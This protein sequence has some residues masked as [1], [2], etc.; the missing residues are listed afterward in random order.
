MRN[1]ETNTELLKL[2][3]EQVEGHLEAKKV[4]LTLVNR[5]KHRFHQQFIRGVNT[6]FLVDPLKVL[7][8]GPSGTGKTHLVDVLQ[9]L[10]HFP[11]IKISAT[12]LNHTG[13]SGGIKLEDIKN[14]IYKEAMIRVGD[15]SYAGAEFNSI[16]GALSQTV[17]FIDEIDKLGDAFEGSSG[18]WSKGTQSQFLTLFDSKDEYRGVSFIFAGAFTDITKKENITNRSIGFIQNSDNSTDNKCID[19]EVI[20]AGIIPELVGRINSIVKLDAFTEDDFYN[21]LVNRIL[22]KKLRDL[23]SLGVLDVEIPEEKLRI[24]AKEASKSDQGIRYLQRFVEKEFLELEFNFEDHSF[25][26]TKAIEGDI[27]GLCWEEL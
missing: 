16:A 13:A 24:V 3:N 15:T 25:N 22:Q 2:Y 4:L 10:V 1:Y 9:R 6:E 12:E 23:A 20:K 14:M 7:L 19:E 8:I 18:K 17:V 11:L 27:P 5:S 26:D 21:I